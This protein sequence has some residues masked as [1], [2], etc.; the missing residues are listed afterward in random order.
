MTLTEQF[1]TIFRAPGA[2]GAENL[3]T[4]RLMLAGKLLMQASVDIGFRKSVG[5]IDI[6]EL[7]DLRRRWLAIFETVYGRDK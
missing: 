1:D 5:D 2:P 6:D 3:Q 4:A 7:D